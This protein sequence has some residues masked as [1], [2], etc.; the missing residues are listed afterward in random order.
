MIFTLLI[1]GASVAGTVLMFV[2]AA[3]RYFANPRR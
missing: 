3:T 1:L 2:P